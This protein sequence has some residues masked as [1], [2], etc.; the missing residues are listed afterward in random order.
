MTNQQNDTVHR[1]TG[2]EGRVIDRDLANGKQTVQLE[3]GP[4]VTSDAVEWQRL[5]D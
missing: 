3:T 4:V 5:T 1:P 2:V